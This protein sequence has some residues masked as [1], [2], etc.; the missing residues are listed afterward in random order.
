MAYIV[1]LRTTYTVTDFT[2]IHIMRDS[3]YSVTSAHFITPLNNLVSG[4]SV[5]QNR[6]LNH[7]LEHKFDLFLKK[8]YNC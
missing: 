5:N 2:S 3:T 8:G 4:L 1:M 7:L 6:A